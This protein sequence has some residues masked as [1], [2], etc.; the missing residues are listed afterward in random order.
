MLKLKQTNQTWLVLLAAFSLSVPPAK[1]STFV[2]GN[3]SGTWS[4]TG[5]PYIATCNLTVPSGQTLI[6]QPGVTII[7]GQGLN[8]T[9]NGNIVADGTAAQRITIRGALG[10]FY[11]DKIQINYTGGAQSRFVNCSI[12]D[13]INALSLDIPTDAIMA[14]QI[15]SCIFSNCTDTCIVEDAMANDWFHPILNG[16]IQNC[17]FHSSSNAIQ[18]TVGGYGHSCYGGY[19]TGQGAI[20]QVIANNLFQNLSGIAIAIKV[21]AEYEARPSNPKVVNNVFLQ[22]AVGMQ[23]TGSAPDF[24]EEITY[25]CFYN[26]QTNFVGYPA[27]VYGTICCVNPNGTPCDLVNNI[28]ENPLFCETTNYTLSKPPARPSGRG[29]ASTLSLMNCNTARV[30]SAFAVACFSAFTA[31]SRCNSI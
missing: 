3:V 18:L 8:M 4:L 23:K 19:C 15:P 21:N 17:R 7:M 27:G 10:S 5:S 28:F 22:C 9:V 2:C 25:N 16:S 14:P 26:N 12:S 24:N 6:I 29:A 30:S 1:A 20:S 11:F 31:R 13:A